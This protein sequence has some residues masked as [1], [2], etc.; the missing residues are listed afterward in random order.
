MNVAFATSFGPGRYSDN[1]SLNVTGTITNNS[2]RPICRIFI[3]CGLAKLSF[4]TSETAGNHLSVVVRPG[5]TKSLGGV[6]S[7]GL[8][9][10][11]KVGSSRLQSP[12]RHF[13][14]STGI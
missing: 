3:A 8:T 13:F 5:E 4:D 7:N 9:A 2:D 1:F 12:D 11:E 14:G 10:V 6:I